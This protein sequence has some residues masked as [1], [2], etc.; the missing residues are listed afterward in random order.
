MR[1]TADTTATARRAPSHHVEPPQPGGLEA[2]QRLTELLGTAHGPVDVWDALARELLSLP[3]VT[4]VH[5]VGPAAE[6]DQATARAYRRPCRPAGAY[7]LSAGAR[8]TLLRGP[9]PAEGRALNGQRDGLPPELVAHLP[10]D[11]PLLIVG[12]VA[13]SDPV[14]AVLVLGQPVQPGSGL[15][16]T[17]A[18]L[19]GVAGVALS[20][21][22]ERS[23]SQRDPRT[24]CLDPGGLWAALDDEIARDERQGASLTCLVV[25]LDDLALISERYGASLHAQT[26]RHVGATLRA[27]LRRLDHVGSLNEG[28]FVV[29]LSGTGATGAEVTARRLLRRLNA[30]KLES[31]GARR[32][33]HVAIGL[34]ERRAQADGVQLIRAA[35]SVL[36]GAR[37]T[38]AVP[39]G[40]PE[41]APA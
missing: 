31:E 8:A 36:R 16:A 28:E 3:D 35:R 4:E 34:A 13:R 25:A 21:L 30:V 24:G 23:R 40:S 32:P 5:L 17:A 26:L 15:S 11:R 22:E 7:L 6:H 33:L 29:L 20:A 10:S 37:P 2:V 1:P 14:I 39:P 9:L 27:E 19:G 12:G 38:A 18:A 41:A